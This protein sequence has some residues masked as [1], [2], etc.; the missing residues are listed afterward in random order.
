M[1]HA[2][3]YSEMTD[4]SY[5]E[6]AGCLGTHILWTLGSKSNLKEDWGEDIIRGHQITGGAECVLVGAPP[7]SDGLTTHTR[8]MNATKQARL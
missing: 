7:I 1:F 8:T 3:Q 2:L 4:S 5:S 6:I